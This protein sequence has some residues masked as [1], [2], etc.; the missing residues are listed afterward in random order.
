MVLPRRYPTAAPEHQSQTVNTAEK[1]PA[2]KPNRTASFELELPRWLSR[3]A[4]LPFFPTAFMDV[5][6]A[7][8]HLF[9]LWEKLD[10]A[11]LQGC[12]ASLRDRAASSA[13]DYSGGICGTRSPL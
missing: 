7:Y 8:L 11:D 9:S 4:M 1:E 2:S 10:A 13:E 6:E 3:L 5:R 12:W